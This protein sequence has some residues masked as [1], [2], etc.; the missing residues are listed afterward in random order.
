[1]KVKAVLA[2]VVLVALA[3]VAAAQAYDRQ[4][5]R[6]S[7]LK[8]DNWGN[9]H[10][11]AQN[12]LKRRYDGLRTAWCTGVIMVGQPRSE[13][14]WVD[15]TTRYWDKGACT[16]RTWTGKTYA[17]VYDAKGRC[18]DCFKIYR[19]RGIGVGDLHG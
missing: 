7:G 3:V 17:L 15:G 19:L 2:L 12:D 14:T 1:M 6:L 11:N 8:P 13:S 5:I 18:G 10:L 4:P 16:G 9:T